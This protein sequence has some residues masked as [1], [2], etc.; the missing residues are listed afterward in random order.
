[1]EPKPLAGKGILVTRPAERAGDLARLIAGAGGR[2]YVYPA[3]RIAPPGDE[4]PA[5]ARLAAIDRYDVAVFVSPTAV[6]RAFALMK[7]VP[8]GMRAAAL[9]AATRDALARHGVHEVLIPAEGA[10][11]EALLALAPMADMTGK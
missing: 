7:G 10:D 4:A 3:L 9:G 1:M 8:P 5:R 6:E 11:S 2:A